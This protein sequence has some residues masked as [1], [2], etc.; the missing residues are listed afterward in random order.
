M[1]SSAAGGGENTQCLIEPERKR[2]KAGEAPSNAD[3]PIWEMTCGGAK[4][5]PR[6]QKRNRNQDKE[7]RNFGDFSWEPETGA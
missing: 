2:G 3:G 4:K 7:E 5:F 1:A 6:K